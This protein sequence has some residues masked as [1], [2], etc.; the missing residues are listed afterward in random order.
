MIIL[1]TVVIN[2]GPKRKDSNAQLMKY[3]A[4]GAESVGAD[5]EYVDLYKLDLRGCMN[6]MICKQE[7]KSCKCHWRDETSPLIERI[8][9]SDCL[10]IGVPIFFTD[11]CSHYKA[12]MERLVFCIVDYKV[13]N[14]FKGKINVGLFYSIF[15]SVSYFE[16]KLRPN[17]KMSEDLFK[18]FKGKVE[19]NSIRHIV[20]RDYDRASDEET[21]KLREEQFELD[22]KKA[23]EIGAELSK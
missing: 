12:L 10:L 13:G 1:K 21:I 20:Q 15:H 9:D 6:C 8:L 11:P 14:A 19:I 17:L 5:V 4:K 2:A 18:M 16:N 22:L 3:A 23:F 7:G